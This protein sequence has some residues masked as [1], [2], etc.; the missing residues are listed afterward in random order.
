MSKG[1]VLPISIKFWVFL[2]LTLVVEGAECG[3]NAVITHV[4]RGLVN[5]Q[6]SRRVAAGSTSDLRSKALS[7]GY[8]GSD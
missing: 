7:F 6:T 5:S 8:L 3:K 4:S 2:L 1:K